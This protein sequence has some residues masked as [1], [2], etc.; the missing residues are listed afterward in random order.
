M[1][2]PSDYGAFLLIGLVGFFFA[3]LLGSIPALILGL[4]CAFKPRFFLAFPGLAV[5]GLIGAAISMVLA[6]LLF[7]KEPDKFAWTLMIVFFL[8]GAG[9]TVLTGLLYRRF[10]MKRCPDFLINS[11]NVGRE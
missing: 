6:G 2:R 11:Q 9:S 5:L 1:G 4:I 7:S 10:L 8:T 3:Y